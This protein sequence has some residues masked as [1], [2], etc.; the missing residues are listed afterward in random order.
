MRQTVP[1]DL[2]C[3]A[4]YIPAL[5]TLPDSALNGHH[6][7]AFVVGRLRVCAMI[8]FH[9]GGI[10]GPDK[11]FVCRE[12]FLLESCKLLLKGFQS[13]LE[14]HL[15]PLSVADG[16]ERHALRYPASLVDSA[17]DIG[18]SLCV[19][20]CKVLHAAHSAVVVGDA[21]GTESVLSD[22]VFESSLLEFIG[23]QSLKDDRA[24]DAVHVFSPESGTFFGVAEGD[25]FRHADNLHVVHFYDFVF[26]MVGN[27]TFV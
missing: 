17:D 9:C 16:V 4:G 7:S 27:A 20:W 21:A 5:Q 26:H 13:S 24:D 11:L 19:A 8:P 2:F 3:V 1:S 6:Y 10:L 14:M 18:E 25:F 23:S 12:P 15:Q 22:S